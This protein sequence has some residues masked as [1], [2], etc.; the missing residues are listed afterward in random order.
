MTIDEKCVGEGADGCEGCN[1]YN[2]NCID[3]IPGIQREMYEATR[4][5]KV[6]E[7][8][9]TIKEKVRTLIK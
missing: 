4:F 6:V 5:D 7:F 8:Y 3:Y 1:G 2:T 9:Q